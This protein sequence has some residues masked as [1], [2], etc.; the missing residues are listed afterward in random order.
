MTYLPFGLHSPEHV[1]IE[2]LYFIDIKQ[3]FV[4]RNFLNN[5][6]QKNYDND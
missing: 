5:I 4:K 6:F 2:K 3:M 1:F